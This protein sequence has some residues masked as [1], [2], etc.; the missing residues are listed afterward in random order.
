MASEG[1][2]D[3]L[4]IKNP[5]DERLQSAASSAILAVFISAGSEQIT[6]TTTTNEWPH[7]SSLA[8]QMQLREK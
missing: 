7:V 1:I 6:S 5:N 3:Q 2:A 8:Q 4:K